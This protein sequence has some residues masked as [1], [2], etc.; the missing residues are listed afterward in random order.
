MN[1][2]KKSKQLITL[3]YIVRKYSKI[4]S[5][6]CVVRQDVQ[7]SVSKVK[8][9]FTVR[10]LA[11]VLQNL[12]LLQAL[13]FRKLSRFIFIFS[14]KI[15][16]T[17]DSAARRACTYVTSK[18][19]IGD[20]FVL[21]QISKNVNMYFFRVFIKEL[22]KDMKKYPK[23][24]HLPI[25]LTGMNHIENKG[26]ESDILSKSELEEDEDKFDEELRVDL[27][28]ETSSLLSNEE[29]HNAPTL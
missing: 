9:S 27:P 21:Y 6:H 23:K 5:F 7:Q 2:R 1:K 29:A 11:F 10:K 18:C 28:E 26:M 12:G 15:G 16:R 20:W 13:F 3:A 19:F 4:I 24:P 17:N 25:V 22:R 14:A 8:I